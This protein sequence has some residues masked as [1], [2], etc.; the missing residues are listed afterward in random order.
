MEQ[1]K[2]REQPLKEEIGEKKIVISVANFVMVVLFFL[3]ISGTVG[4]AIS[5]YQLLK[6]EVE[7]LNQKN[8][9]L[10]DAIKEITNNQQKINEKISD[11]TGNILVLATQVTHLNRRDEF[12]TT[13]T[14]G[15]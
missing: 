5:T 3:G 7:T 9:S 15:E 2:Q 14:V 11:I 13:K 12:T 6:A 8:N 4:T 1:K 10:N